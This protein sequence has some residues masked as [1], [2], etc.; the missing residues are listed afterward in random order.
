MFENKVL[1][2]SI[3]RNK[4]ELSDRKY[5][6]KNLQIYVWEWKCPRRMVFASSENNT[7]SSKPSGSD[8]YEV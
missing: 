8:D 4:E 6:M 3:V 7:S 1:K 5:E 2:W